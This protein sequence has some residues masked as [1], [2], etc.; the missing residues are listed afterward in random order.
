MAGKI[1]SIIDSIVEKRANGNATI[2]NLTKS[3]IVMKGI[4]PEKYSSDSPDD[5][6]VIEKL[7][8]LAKEL[9]VNI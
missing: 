8:T 1:K 6:M 7:L 9:N 4:I 3:K 5:P 2:A